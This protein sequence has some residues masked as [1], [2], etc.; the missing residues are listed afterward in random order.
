MERTAWNVNT[1]AP[2][3]MRA[4]ATLRPAAANAHREYPASTAKTAVPRDSLA[5]PA[6]ENAP[7][8]AQAVDAIDYSATANVPPDSTAKCAT[9]D[10]LLSPLDPTA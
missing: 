4:N 9:N 7:T 6:N 8:T 1:I 5:N 10:V 2:A 3:K